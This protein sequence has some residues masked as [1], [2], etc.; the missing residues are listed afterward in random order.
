MLKFFENVIDFFTGKKQR[1][2]EENNKRLR[3]QAEKDN[4]LWRQRIQSAGGQKYYDSPP[5]KPYGLYR[6]TPDGTHWFQVGVNPNGYQWIQDH[7]NIP[8]PTKVSDFIKWFGP[9]EVWGKQ[10]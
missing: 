9:D 7:M 5:E 4:E 6:A 1:E 3:I 10:N 8:F 2:I